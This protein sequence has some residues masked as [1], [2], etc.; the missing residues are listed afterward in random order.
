[1]A[2]TAARGESSCRFGQRRSGITLAAN[3]TPDWAPRSSSTIQIGNN[4]VDDQANGGPCD[5][6]FSGLID[7]VRI[8]T[9]KQ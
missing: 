8:S 9:A 6:S 5:Y 4:M 2:N 1:V 3:I 7:E